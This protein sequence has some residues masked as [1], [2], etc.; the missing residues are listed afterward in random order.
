[1][2]HAKIGKY[3]LIFVHDGQLKRCFT[4][5]SILFQMNR[6]DVVACD[7]L[8]RCQILRLLNIKW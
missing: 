5:H 8:R 3:D 7:F 2:V 6:L 4:W 1:M